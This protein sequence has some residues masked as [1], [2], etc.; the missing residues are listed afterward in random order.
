MPLL[1]LNFS[2]KRELIS[3]RSASKTCDVF[4]EMDLLYVIY[5]IYDNY[6]YMYILS[7]YIYICICVRMSSDQFWPLKTYHVARRYI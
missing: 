7:I 3:I 6:L 1:P 2:L 5:I 4:F